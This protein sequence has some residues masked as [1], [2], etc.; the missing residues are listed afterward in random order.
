MINY[1]D[2]GTGIR[3]A[4]VD[5]AVE[6]IREWVDLVLNHVRIDQYVLELA[7]P[8]IVKYR[9]QVGE[10]AGSRHLANPELTEQMPPLW[11]SKINGARIYAALNERGTDVL[12]IVARRVHE[13]GVK[14]LA[15][16]R[17]GDTHHTSIDPV[18]PACAQF[19]LDHPEWTIKR[20]D[21]LAEGTEETALD[22]SI[23]EVREHRL[24]IIKE[25]A[26]RPEVDGIE[27]NFMRWLKFFQRELAPAK[28]PIM[29][30][31]VGQVHRICTEA[32]KK[33]GR[34]KVSLGGRIAST[35]EECRLAGLDPA[36]WIKLGYMDYIIA[37]DWNWCDLQMP[38]EEFAAITKGT[39]C[40]LL[41]QMGDG[42]GGIWQGK[43][44]IKDRKRGVA[45]LPDGDGYHAFRNTDAEARACAYNIYAWGADG[46]SIWNIC[47][48]MGNAQHKTPK[49]PG[50]GMEYRKRMI[51]W[52]QQVVSPEKV[53]A[54]KRHYHYCP[55]WKSETMWPRLH[56]NRKLCESPAGG[57]HC[58][59][60]TF[61][62][63]SAGKRQ[64]YTFRM[65]DGRNGEKLEG[66][67][68]FQIFHI[69]PENRVDIDINGTVV[70]AEKIKLDYRPQA[71]PPTTWFEFSL[72]DCGPFQGDNELGM[73]I[74]WTGSKAQQP[75]MEELEVIVERGMS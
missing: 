47:D 23:P 69:T 54:G 27:L 32:A 64:V 6:Y 73:T 33:R 25:L 42:F 58:Q 13:H 63:G 9:S 72:T 55:L 7:T 49:N 35:L 46:I 18:N 51:S 24:A 15:E 60:V 2:D 5:N 21:K 41:V 56:P 17:M 39:E 12:A 43:P 34:Q 10:L 19:L 38:V 67:M 40:K 74:S 29:T 22:Y 37:A 3:G 28:A 31:F 30:E 20:T 61:G 68:R 1:N 59:I 57:K 66:I 53:L 36:E 52:M 71:D 62:K 65:A 45:V 8:D 26:Y 16:F 48:H 70:G 44:S 14:F 75:Y 11:Q 4:T 50:I